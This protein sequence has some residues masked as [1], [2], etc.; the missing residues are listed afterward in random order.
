MN[1]KTV[2]ESNIHL[3]KLKKGGNM[4]K[5]CLFLLATIL[6]V[7]ASVSAQ[8]AHPVNNFNDNLYHDDLL[9]NGQAVMKESRVC[10]HHHEKKHRPII[11]F[12]SFFI[13]GVT[14]TVGPG[15][16]V[17]FAEQFVTPV[18][19]QTVL[20]TGA[21]T[22][23]RAG[24]YEISYGVASQTIG[25]QEVILQLNGV[26]VPGSNILFAAAFQL[27]SASILL[28]IQ[29]NQ[30]LKVVNPTGNTLLVGAGG[31]LAAYIT[32]ERVSAIPREHLS[33]DESSESD[34]N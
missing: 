10:S 18:G 3:I 34:S 22:I 15:G 17:P 21:F 9:D 5:L 27:T 6:S 23:R 12:G 24:I 31:A 4:R 2:C 20:G 11:A 29:A 13:N 1:F 33:S 19:I 28:T 7:G 30:V 32:I 26:N 8:V 16:T 14:T 25:N